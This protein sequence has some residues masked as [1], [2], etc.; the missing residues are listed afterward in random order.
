MHEKIV[1]EAYIPRPAFS[2]KMRGKQQRR[3]LQFFDSV[4]R[5]ACAF[6]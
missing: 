5:F 2:R 6:I 4:M 1:D 3:S